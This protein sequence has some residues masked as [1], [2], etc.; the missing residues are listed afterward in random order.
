MSSLQMKRHFAQSQSVSADFNLVIDLKKTKNKKKNK[1]LFE[2]TGS[3]LQPFGDE[4][5]VHT[6]VCIKCN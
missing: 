4:V 5:C 2:I 1:P 6:S 3:F